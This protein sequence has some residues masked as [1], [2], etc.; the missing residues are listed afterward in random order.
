M[1]V[2]ELMLSQ[3]AHKAAVAAASA[4]IVS[5][6]KLNSLLKGVVKWP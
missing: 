5:I 1:C 2:D 4:T 6:A 3:A